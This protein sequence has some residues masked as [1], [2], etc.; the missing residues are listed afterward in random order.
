MLIQRVAVAAVGLPLLA[1]LLWAPEPAFAVALEVILAVAVFE[2]LRALAPDRPLSYALSA[3]AAVTLFVAIARVTPALPL[4]SFLAVAALALAMILR[5]GGRLGESLGGWW[6]TASLY[7]GVLGAHLALLR[8]EPEGQGWLVVLLAATFAT[9]TGA[10]AAGRLFGRHIL[11][12]AISPNKTW[13]GA[14]GGLLAGGVAAVA[15]TLGIPSIEVEPVG[16]VLIALLPAAAI[17]GDLLESALKRRMEVKDMSGLLPGHGG[18]MD[19]LDSVLVVGVC[20]YWIV[21]WLQI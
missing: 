15:V 8:L 16:L 20:L 11:A 3:A 9:D 2:M 4:W 18:L 6:I 14:A 19:R 21:R 7:V 1:L 17:A 13:E 12:P 5:P 10:Y